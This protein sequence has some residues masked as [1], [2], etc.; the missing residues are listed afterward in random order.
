M[1][2]LPAPYLLAGD[3]DYNKA[4]DMLL[5][6]LPL[7]MISATIGLTLTGCPAPGELNP[8]E[9]PDRTSDTDASISDA[10]DGSQQGDAAVA[11]DSGVACVPT[12]AFFKEEVW[13]TFMGTTC[14]S[15]HGPDGIGSGG[16]DF[17]LIL[18]MNDADHASNLEVLGTVAARTAD[19]Q[20]LLLAK[21]SGQVAH[22]GGPILA[23]DSP[24]Y[25]ALSALV[26]RLETP[27]S[28]DIESPTEDAGV[29]DSAMGVDAVD[30]SAMGADAV[31][32]S[33][34]GADTS[35]LQLW[36]F[37]GEGDNV[38]A[39]TGMASG[40]HFILTSNGS[41]TATFENM[42]AG[43]YVIRAR[44]WGDQGGE[45]LTRMAFLLNS[46]TIEEQDV[47]GGSAAAA[48]IQQAR[49]SARVGS[50]TIGIAFLNDAYDADTGLDRN[51]RVDWFEVEGPQ[52]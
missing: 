4:T 50:Q 23:T 3:Y 19:G 34:M 22:G 28:C 27:V 8:G 17:D 48:T 32:D 15:C 51:L 10:S 36:R 46:M 40:D 20:S 43:E 33:A 38:T 29:D 16:S 13:G 1:R 35:G 37:E 26:V 9:W 30:D 14:F 39:T 25:M 21:G 18:P 52:P 11:E 45:A 41:L 24:D 6:R 31:D 5:K 2:P 44:V 7:L 12:L 49:F 42:A 47:R